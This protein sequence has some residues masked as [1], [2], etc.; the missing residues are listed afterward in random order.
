MIFEHWRK[1]QEDPSLYE[2]N[3]K[4]AE[5]MHYESDDVVTEERIKRWCTQWKKIR[6]LQIEN[7]SA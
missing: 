1:W 6:L 5:E 7:A 4:F 3:K 2:S